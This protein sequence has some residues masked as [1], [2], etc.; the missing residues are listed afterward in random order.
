MTMMMNTEY[1][2]NIDLNESAVCEPSE[3]DLSDAEMLFE[4]AE[5]RIHAVEREADGCGG[6]LSCD[7]FLRKAISYP[8]LDPGDL[9]KLLS[10]IQKGVAAEKV[11]ERLEDGEV[12]EELTA[13]IEDGQKAMDT[14][15]TGSQRMVCAIVGLTLHLSRKEE[16]YSDRIDKG[17]L[18]AIQEANIALMKAAR[19]FDPSK[20]CKFSTYATHWIRGAAKG[21]SDYLNA[22]FTVHIPR[23]VYTDMK[24]ILWMA[25][26]VDY[27][28]LKTMTYQDISKLTDMPIKRVR[29]AMIALYRST[30]DYSSLPPMLRSDYAKMVGGKVVEGLGDNSAQEEIEW[31]ETGRGGDA[32][33]K[34]APSPYT[35][36]RQN[37]VREA[38]LHALDTLP[39]NQR[40]V[41]ELNCGMTADERPMSLVEISKEMGISPPAVR[42]LKERALWNL[43]NASRLHMI[44]TA[45]GTSASEVLTKEAKRYG[46]LYTNYAVKRSNLRVDARKA[47]DIFRDRYSDSGD[48][49]EAPLE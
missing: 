31:Y 24:K 5:E 9:E 18:D 2:D 33:S 45:V 14:L 28:T 35:V 7:F 30:S 48:G 27:F 23:N 41:L 32:P 6:M 19:R 34:Y 12:S 37:E 1:Q 39:E 49:L 4:M 46:E 22:N 44:C 20:V 25:H 17:A 40:R 10:V 36:V 3:E 43:R 21:Y 29:L 38:L 15:I 47:V 42:Q 11:A 26:Q 16:Y 8:P 13:R